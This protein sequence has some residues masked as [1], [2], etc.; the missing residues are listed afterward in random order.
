[1]IE[2]LYAAAAGMEAQQTQ[3]D[4][5]SNDIANGDTPGY[6]STVVGFRSLLNS[7]GGYNS[8]DTIPTGTG[9][10]AS[11]IGYSQTP[12][13]VDP[14]GQP[15]DVAIEGEGYLEVRQPNGTTGLTRDGSLQLNANGQ[16][17]TELGMPLQPPITVPRGTDPSQVTIG[18]N[19]AVS[20]GGRKLGQIGVVTVPAPDQLLSTGSGVF[21]ATAGSGAITRATGVSLQQGSL[22]Q[23]NV[24]LSAAMTSMTTAEQGYDLASKAISYETQ[25]GQIAA[26]VKQ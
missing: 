8:A 23:S 19:G 15:L 6:Q 5:I 26:T 24:N 2:G 20:V 21:S 7:S 1:M 16:L 9:A 3:L 4:A 11:M 14:T 13:A 22:E 25:M 10:A 18:P 12:G 17:T